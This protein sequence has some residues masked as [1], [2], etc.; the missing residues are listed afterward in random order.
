VAAG[1]TARDGLGLDIHAIPRGQ[2]SVPA[3]GAPASIPGEIK[4]SLQLTVRF[5]EALGGSLID[6]FMAE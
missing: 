1:S 2:A 6:D 5:R 3:C 4:K